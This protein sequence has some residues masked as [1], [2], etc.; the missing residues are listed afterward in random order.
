MR[1]CCQLIGVIRI[2]EAAQAGGRRFTARVAIGIALVALA[3]VIWYAHFVFLLAF[4]GVLLA[5]LLDFL[6]GRWAELTG[7]RR[8]WAFAMVACGTLIL[9]G[10]LGW[11]VFPRIADQVSHLIQGLPGSMERMQ[12][13]LNARD[14]GRTLLTHFPQILASANLTG[15]ASSLA[16]KAL[17]GLIGLVVIGVVG[18]YAG[19]NP[20]AYERGIVRLFP[21]PH[22]GRARQVLYEVARTLRWWMLGQLVPMGVMGV[23]SAIGLALL[24]VHPA[25]TLGIFTGLLVF[26]P[27]IGSIIAYVVTMLATLIQDPSQILYV[28]FLFVGIHT[29]EGYLLTPMVQRRAVY[30]PPGLT[31]L[32]QVL[33]GLLLGLLGFALATPLT[34]GVLVLIRMLYLHE[35]PR[36]HE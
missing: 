25:F 32:A 10:F 24:G 7:M 14:W 31:I 17:E 18:L 20:A 15:I 19:A 16:S 26:I 6:A 22:R 8:G 35:Q 2:N 33:M 9:A 13:Y 12:K 11:E 4:A 28:T 30:L 21:E 36:H 34:A 29:A 5:I 23:A 27:Y 1:S 3:G